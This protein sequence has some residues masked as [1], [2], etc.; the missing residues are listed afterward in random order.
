MVFM[1]FNWTQSTPAR[2]KVQITFSTCIESSR[3]SWSHGGLT[4]PGATEEPTG[5]AHGDVED[6]LQAVQALPGARE[7]HHG[8]RE[9]QS[10]FSLEMCYYLHKIIIGNKLFN[11]LS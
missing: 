11:P 3:S 2:D 5:D 8:A 9:D 1:S 6:L 7:P 4:G 10:K